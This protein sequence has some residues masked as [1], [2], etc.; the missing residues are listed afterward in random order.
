M[1]TQPS[2]EAIALAVKLSGHTQ[3]ERALTHPANE[4]QDV[5]FPCGGC[6]GDARTIDEAL[7][8]PARN[9]ALLL[10]QGL[11]DA[12]QDTDV[13]IG[14][15]EIWDMIGQLRDALALIKAKV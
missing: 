5:D 7:Q 11:T 13:P 6:L 2:A 4:A 1:S 15:I 12:A 14:E 8:L 3:C 9:A 10:A